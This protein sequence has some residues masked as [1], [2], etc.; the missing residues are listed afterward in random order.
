MAELPG[1]F[2]MPLPSPPSLEGGRGPGSSES[3]RIKRFSGLWACAPFSRGTLEIYRSRN[4]TC[5]PRS[6]DVYHW[7]H[8]LLGGKKSKIALDFHICPALRTGYIWA[9]LWASTPLEGNLAKPVQCRQPA[10]GAP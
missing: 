4:P 9:S 7:N 3:V 6:A 8:F 5:L 1:L 10:D 2:G